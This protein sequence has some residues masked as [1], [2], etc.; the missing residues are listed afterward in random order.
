MDH[1]GIDAEDRHQAEDAQETGR[2][3]EADGAQELAGIRARGGLGQPAG[4]DEVDQPGPDGP[5]RR[6]AA[7][8]A[9]ATAGA[10]RRRAS[11]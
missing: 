1:I 5:A 3:G 9:R 11:A 6:C 7:G 2:G 8:R 10:C 4:A